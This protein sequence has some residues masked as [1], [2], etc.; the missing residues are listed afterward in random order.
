M[1]LY[2]IF[3]LP[4]FSQGKTQFSLFS[5][6]RLSDFLN[7]KITSLNGICIE[8]YVN[9]NLLAS[10]SITSSLLK[11]T[12]KHLLIE[13]VGELVSVIDLKTVILQI[14]QTCK[15][16][17]SALD[18]GDTICIHHFTLK[19]LDAAFTVLLDP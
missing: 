1:N 13:A 7:L 18:Y 2:T 15:P 14:V 5:K 16:F 4:A 17:L 11:L 9:I 8:Q 12:L 6:T 10:G 19:A 3:S